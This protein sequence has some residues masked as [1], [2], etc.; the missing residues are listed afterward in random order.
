M[1]NATYYFYIA[2]FIELLDTVSAMIKWAIMRL[3]Y[4]LSSVNSF[5]KRACAAIPMGLDV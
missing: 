5:F 2:K 1:A 4:F 3:S